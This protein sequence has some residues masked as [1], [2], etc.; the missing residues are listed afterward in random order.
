M[1]ETSNNPAFIELFSVHRERLRRMVQLRMDRR[2]SGRVDAS[3]VIQEAFA[4]A[5]DRY[6][7][8]VEQD[9]DVSSF[10]WLR[11]LTAQ[12]LAH[13]HR[14][15]L[16]AKARD[17]RR[18]VPLGRQCC[19]DASSL[20][21]AEHLAGD[22]TSPSQALV[23]KER[24]DRLMVTLAETSDTDREI[25]ALRHFEQLSNR[26]AAETLNISEDACYRRYIHAL[27]RLRRALAPEIA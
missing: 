15:H 12:K 20:A 10:V 7:E 26:E 18:E 3:D 22:Q 19:V 27:Q 9:D 21:I 13:F 14:R 2:M 23:R 25:I 6:D 8:F 16:G 11:F 5:A 4:E 24:K 1:A 17:V